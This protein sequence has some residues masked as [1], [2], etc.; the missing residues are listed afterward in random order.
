MISP[1]PYR[2]AIYSNAMQ[3]RK[4]RT[5]QPVRC[6][7]ARPD[8]FNLRRGETQ[9]ALG[10][11]SPGQRK[12]GWLYHH[13][14]EYQKEGQFQWLTAK[15]PE[16]VK[17]G[18]FPAMTTNAWQTGTGS[19]NPS[20]WRA[21]RA[22]STTMQVRFQLSAVHKAGSRQ[23]AWE[24]EEPIEIGAKRPPS[25]RHEAAGL[26]TSRR[27]TRPSAA[28]APPGRGRETPENRR[29]IE[30]GPKALCCATDGDGSE[31][32]KYGP[33]KKYSPR[34]GKRWSPRRGNHHRAVT[35]KR[36]SSYQGAVTSSLISALAGRWITVCVR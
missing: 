2:H 12:E 6:P 16:M 23:P 19:R 29:S 10:V 32:K 8:Y 22:G 3:R 11:P 35:Q 30:M 33:P 20:R 4:T 34:Y 24:P 9:R 17:E 15:P 7:A 25:Q 1:L 14:M 21:K 26:T 31:A 13:I 28:R 27:T 36:E 5:E 18:W